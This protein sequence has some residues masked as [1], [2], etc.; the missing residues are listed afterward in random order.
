MEITADEND[1]WSK[2]GICRAIIS[3]INSQNFVNFDVGHFAC[4][5]Q[6]RINRRCSFNWFCPRVHDVSKSQ[7]HGRNSW[8]FRIGVLFHTTIQKD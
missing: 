8:H 1:K 4:L 6:I 7:E 5:Y 2:F 3:N